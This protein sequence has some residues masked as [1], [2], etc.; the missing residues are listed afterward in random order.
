[1]KKKESFHSPIFAA[2]FL[3]N[4]DDGGGETENLVWLFTVPPDEEDVSMSY[5]SAL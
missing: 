2:R 1:M 5:Y 4:V 3:K